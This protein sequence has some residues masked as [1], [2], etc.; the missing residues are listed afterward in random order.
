MRAI[1]IPVG[2]IAQSKESSL[3]VLNIVQARFNPQTDLLEDTRLSVYLDD[4]NFRTIKTERLND[5]Y[6]DLGLYSE[7]I[8]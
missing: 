6:D 7:W 8:R 1:D 3:T 5:D 4:G 2:H